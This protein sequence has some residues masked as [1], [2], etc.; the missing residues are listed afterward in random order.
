[1]LV[2][3]AFLAGGCAG[4]RPPAESGP[5]A[6]SGEPERTR[7]SVAAAAPRERSYSFDADAGGRLATGLSALQDPADG[8]WRVEATPVAASVPHV[9]A[10]KAKGAGE[11]KALLIDAA[12]EKLDLVVQIRP[13]GASPA[14]EAGFVLGYQDAGRYWAASWD[15][16]GRTCRIF[17]VTGEAREL[18]AEGTLPA[19]DAPGAGWDTLAVS[20]RGDTISC[21]VNGVPCGAVRDKTFTR[22]RSGLF[23]RGGP[24]LFDDLT[25]K[26]R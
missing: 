6:P 20:C 3:A 26:P 25:I 14:G 15:P 18:L 5:A 7:A 17:C 11:G 23:A 16:A 13:G 9:L 19:S 8:S 22:G 12:S 21:T 1:M 24:F 2:V 10:W 4:T